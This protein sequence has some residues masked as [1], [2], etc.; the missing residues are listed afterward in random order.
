MFEVLYSSGYNIDKIMFEVAHS[1][2]SMFKMCKWKSKVVPCKELFKSIKTNAGICC[3]FNYFGDKN[4][5]YV[6]TILIY[7]NKFNVSIL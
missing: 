7:C 5:E 3:S 6:H 4:K 2:E 1:C